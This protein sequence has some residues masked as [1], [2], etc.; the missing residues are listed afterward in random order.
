MPQSSRA[1]ARAQTHRKV[2]RQRAGSAL[3]LLHGRSRAGGGGG[4]GCWL[5][6]YDILQA[7]PHAARPPARHRPPL[8]AQARARARHPAAHLQ[9]LPAV[10]RD[11]GD[12]LLAAQQ[13]VVVLVQRT[14]AAGQGRRNK[15]ALC[16][17]A[18]GHLPQGSACGAR[19]VNLVLM[20][21]CI[22]LGA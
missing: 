1:R 18:Y 8:P 3:P 10:R 21:I 7:A 2:A 19:D 22:G 20:P 5:R 11:G 13:P 4:G 12:E 16:S 17:R 9:G 14:A 6:Q 15:S